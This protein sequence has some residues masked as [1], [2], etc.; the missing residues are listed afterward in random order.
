MTRGL[1]LTAAMLGC[2][3]FLGLDR[4]GWAKPVIEPDLSGK[5]FC[6]NDGGTK[7][8]IEMEDIRAPMTRKAHGK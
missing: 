4:T 7:P 6:L 3:L 5:K 8:T 1:R 2:C